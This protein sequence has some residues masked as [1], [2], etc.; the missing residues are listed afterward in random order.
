[1]LTLT[2]LLLR[3]ALGFETIMVK[4]SIALLCKSAL[5]ISFAMASIS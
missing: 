2:D 1:M 3:S 5:A 4:L